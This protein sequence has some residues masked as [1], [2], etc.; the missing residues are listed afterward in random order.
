MASVPWSRVGVM[1]TLDRRCAPTFGGTQFCM[2][3]V[4]LAEWRASVV[5]WLTYSGV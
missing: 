2:W 3:S 5:V 4:Q 1:A